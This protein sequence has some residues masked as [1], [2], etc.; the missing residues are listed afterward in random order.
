MLQKTLTER[1]GS[2][3]GFLTVV[4]LLLIPSS[5]F[6]T[7]QSLWV[8][9]ASSAWFADHSRAF[10]PAEYHFLSAVPQMPAF[11][12]L[13][14]P[15]VHL[16][17]DSERALRSINLPFAALFLA[18]LVFLCRRTDERWSWLPVAPFALFP[19]LTYYVNECRPYV[20]LLAV[21]TAA[22]VAFISY[23]RTDSR[24]AACWCCF[25]SLAAFSMH[26]LGILTPF[27]LVSYVLLQR[28][29]RIQLSR[30]WKNWIVPLL[31]SLPGYLALL[32]YYS[33]AKV[34]RLSRGQNA[35]SL[36]TPGTVTSSWRNVAFFFYEAMGFG[37]L[38]PPR[39]DLRV[40][41]NWHIFVGYS[42]WMILGCVAIAAL[43]FLFFKSGRKAQAAE[44]GKGYA[45]ACM[46][47]LALL[48]LAARTMHFGFFG[49]HGMAIAGLLSCSVMLVL[50]A[51]RVAFKTRV[52]TI[53]LLFVAWG[54]SS[55]RLLFVYSYGKDDVRSAL[56]AAKATG[57]PILWDAGTADAAY[58][59]AYDMNVLSSE[60]FSAPPSYPNEHWQNKT[61]LHVLNAYTQAN[62]DQALK[63]YAYGSYVFVLGKADVYD[64][65]EAWRKKL[66]VW[67]AVP[68][69]RLNGFDLWIVTIPG[70]LQ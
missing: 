5:L 20:A 43:I 59:G 63:P 36:E 29:A 8:D 3:A 56:A 68:I 1:A 37:G 38:G 42:V 27:I 28:G 64:P 58:Y 7:S 13:L 4:A 22:G 65:A 70:N 21:S 51:E 23:L 9:E 53:L 16:F 66:A 34:E 60:M 54:V 19:L 69:D 18:S 15:W 14:I 11:H 24:V 52:A 33:H 2:A 47:G 40:R 12:L 17:G 39:N 31:V 61:A 41:A 62:L 6:V 35:I 44:S 32:V 67:R 46:A 30:Q 26:L 48:F 57:L 55:A 45:L 50:T 25:F 49:R 10:N